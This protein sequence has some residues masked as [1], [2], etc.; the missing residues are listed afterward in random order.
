MVNLLSTLV[1][2]SRK[3]KRTVIYSFEITFASTEEQDV[4][5]PI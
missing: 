3:E 2:K 1:G 5:Q 4:L